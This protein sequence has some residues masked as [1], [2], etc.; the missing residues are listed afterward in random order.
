MTDIA[1]EPR[2]P[3]P[4]ILLVDLPDSATAKL[5]ASGFNVQAGTFGRPYRVPPPSD[6]FLPVVAQANLPNYTEQEVVVIDLTPP[7]I[8]DQPE[9]RKHTS[10]GA[11]D[12]YAKAS[13]GFIDPRPRVMAEVSDDWSR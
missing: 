5:T 3:K 2:F 8:A 13:R 10:E 12:W 6:D 9:G 4:K 1:A 7:E 11:P